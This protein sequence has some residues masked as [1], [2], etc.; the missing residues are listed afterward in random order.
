MPQLF[1][2]PLFGN[3]V[4]LISST[5]HVAP[6][7]PLAVKVAVLMADATAV[8]VRRLRPASTLIDD[9]KILFVFDDAL[10]SFKS[11]TIS[12]A[13]AFCPDRLFCQIVQQKT[14]VIHPLALSDT[15]PHPFYIDQQYFPLQRLADPLRQ[16]PYSRPTAYHCKDALVHLRSN[17]G[18]SGHAFG[19]DMPIRV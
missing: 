18:S 10:T 11:A 19:C 3:S 8:K 12:I 1:F 2:P 13:R 6:S 17:S 5:S 15:F 16:L 14:V 4:A 9:S 7:A